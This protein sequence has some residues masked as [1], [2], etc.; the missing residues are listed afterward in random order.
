MREVHIYLG[1]SGCQSFMGIWESEVMLRN[2][3][4][5]NPTLSAS[6]YLHTSWHSSEIVNLAEPINGH[7][8]FCK[9]SVRLRA[10]G[11]SAS[12]LPVS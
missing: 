7:Q 8:D 3:G 12:F 11:H 6:T 9:L 4:Q 1:L 5:L 2:A 10:L